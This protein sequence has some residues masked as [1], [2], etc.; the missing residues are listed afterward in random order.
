MDEKHLNHA[1]SFTFGD[2]EALC[3]SLLALVRSGKKTAT[4]GALRDVESGEEEMPSPGQ[5]WIARE[6]DGTPGLMIETLDVCVCAFDKVSEEF[7][8]AEGENESLQGWRRDHKAYFERN[9][10]FQSD[11]LLV[12]ERFRLI[13]DYA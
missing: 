4:C 13:E 1:G 12:C 8:R 3:N 10:G 6:W 5:K 9:G 11:M 7:A 2:S